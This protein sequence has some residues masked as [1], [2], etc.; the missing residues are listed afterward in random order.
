[1]SK[2]QRLR[3]RIKEELGIELE[4]EFTRLYPGYWQRSRGAWSWEAKRPAGARL[5]VGSQWSMTELL[6]ADKLT[7][8]QDGGVDTAIIPDDEPTRAG[9]SDDE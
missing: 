9:E 6:K 2:W 1:M 4:E 5:P 3:K 7:A 8:Y